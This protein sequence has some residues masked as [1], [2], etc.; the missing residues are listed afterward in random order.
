MAHEPRVF[1]L[2]GSSF[3]I[4]PS[5]YVLKGGYKEPHKKVAM[6]VIL[7]VKAFLPLPPQIAIDRFIIVPDSLMY[8]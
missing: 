6:T 2:E 7:G 1:K 8:S 4:M 5:I 3:G